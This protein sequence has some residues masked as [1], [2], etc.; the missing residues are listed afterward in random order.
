[1]CASSAHREKI[2]PTDTG[3]SFDHNTPLG[4]EFK[5]RRKIAKY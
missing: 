4:Q 2:K 1:M 5:N 3:E